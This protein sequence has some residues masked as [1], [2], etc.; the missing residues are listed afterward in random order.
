MQHLIRAT[1]TVTVAIL[2]MG[3]ASTN[4]ESH[5]NIVTPQDQLRL[6]RKAG[7]TRDRGAVPQLVETLE[8][9]DPVVR[10]MAIQALDRIT[11]TRL[12]YRPY[13]ND[14]YRREAIDRWVEAVRADRF[15]EARTKVP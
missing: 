2:L 4:S 14:A 10:M 5:T 1:S 7:E 3:C 6:I 11:G 9:A 8:S 13:G 12:G 15:A